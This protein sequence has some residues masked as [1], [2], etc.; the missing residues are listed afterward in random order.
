MSNLP[1]EINDKLNIWQK[2]KIRVFLWR[3]H[4]SFIDYEYAP[5]YIKKDEKVKRKIFKDKD[6]TNQ[7][8]IEKCIP[9]FKEN[10][11]FFNEDARK[12]IIELAITERPKL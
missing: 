3:K 10:K 12:K 4:H 11:N 5:E 6:L 8:T 9:A 2:I 7:R 1:I